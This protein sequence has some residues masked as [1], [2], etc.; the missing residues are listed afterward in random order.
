[1]PVVLTDQSVQGQTNKSADLTAKKAGDLAGATVHLYTNDYT[2]TPQSVVGDFTEATFT[3]YAAVAVA[4][5]TANRLE[6]SGAVS[7]DATNVIPF[8]GPGDATGQSI[9]GYFV[10]S[11][12]GGTPYLYAVKFA[13]PVPLNSPADV[14][15]LVATFRI[16]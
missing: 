11:A 1:M 10:K 8:V 3:G 9:M 15:A 7:T 13:A 5:W 4:G 2:P 16:P 12:G 14:L 6:A